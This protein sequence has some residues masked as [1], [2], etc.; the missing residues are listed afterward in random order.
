MTILF[1]GAT[2][3]TVEDVLTRAKSNVF[4]NRDISVEI[5]QITRNDA[6]DREKQFC[7]QNKIRGYFSK[8]YV[9]LSFVF[10]ISGVAF[11]VSLTEI[12]R[13][14]ISP[15]PFLNYNSVTVLFVSIGFLLGMLALVSTIN[16]ATLGRSWKKEE[17]LNSTVAEIKNVLVG[18]LTNRSLKGKM[19]VW[20]YTHP[21]SPI[22]LYS[23]E[24]LGDSGD[25]EEYFFYCFEDS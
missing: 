12:W 14:V 10:F 4:R 17:V 2:L 20:Q 8:N 13:S 24:G 7:E 16:R 1:V 9:L 23:L 3:G 15:E 18:I 11:L 25:T 6:R 19:I 22:V 5:K 21:N